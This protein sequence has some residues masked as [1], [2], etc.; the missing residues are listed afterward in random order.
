[1]KGSEAVCRVLSP[2]SGSPAGKGWVLAFAFFG[3]PHL[4][5]KTGRQ[6]PGQPSQRVGEGPEQ[7]Q[8]GFLR[9]YS[10]MGEGRLGLPQD[11]HS[12]RER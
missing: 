12:N 5:P 3:P 2:V 1:M 4:G 8:T 7:P 10:M 6:W 11:L 9:I